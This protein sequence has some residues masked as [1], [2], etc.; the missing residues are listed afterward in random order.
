MHRA[1]DVTQTVFT[2]AARKAERLAS[3]PAMTGWL[4]NSAYRAAA[5]LMRAEDRRERRER[6]AAALAAVYGPFTRARGRGP[7]INGRLS[8]TVSGER[9]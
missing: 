1:Q 9:L 2:D 4:Y 3:H 8:C 5:A 6:E 7:P